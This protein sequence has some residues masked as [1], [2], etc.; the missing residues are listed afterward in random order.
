M[1]HYSDGTTLAKAGD[2]VIGKTYNLHG[3]TIVGT[4]LEVIPGSDSCN[5]RVAFAEVSSHPDAMVADGGI[6]YSTAYDSDVPNQRRII[7]P[8]YDYGDTKAFVLLAR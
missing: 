4:V 8:G 6:G 1:P 7:K 2:L 5:L 3:R